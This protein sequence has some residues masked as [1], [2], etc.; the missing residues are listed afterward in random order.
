MNVRPFAKKQTNLFKDNS[1]MIFLFHIISFPKVTITFITHRQN[2][3]NVE[4]FS[5]FRQCHCHLRD[6]DKKLFPALK[7]NV[8]PSHPG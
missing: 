3:A 8:P 5:N 4:S 1:P 6:G 2:V 7:K